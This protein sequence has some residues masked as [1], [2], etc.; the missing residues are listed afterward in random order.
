MDN[1]KL[2]L[3]AGVCSALSF[4]VTPKVFADVLIWYHF[5]E[6]E[7][8]SK[9]AYQAEVVN[10]APSGGFAGLIDCRNDATTFANVPGVLPVYQA[11]FPDGVRLY[12]PVTKTVRDNK[13]A[14]QFKTSINQNLPCSTVRIVDGDQLTPSDYTIEMFIKSYNT[15]KCQQRLITSAAWDL[16]ANGNGNG[17]GRFQDSGMSATVNGNALCDQSWHHVAIV[18]SGGTIIFYEDYKEIMRQTNMGTVN[19][20]TVAD[21][22]LGAPIGRSYGGWEGLIDEVRVCDVALSAS[23]FLHL[24]RAKT[25]VDPN[26]YFHFS[27]EEYDLDAFGELASLATNLFSYADLRSGGAL[28]NDAIAYQPGNRLFWDGTYGAKPTLMASELAGD[29]VRFGVTNGVRRMESFGLQFNA[30]QKKHADYESLSAY[31]HVDDTEDKTLAADSYTSECFIKY[32]SAPENKAQYIMWQYGGVNGS[33]CNSW[34]LYQN[35]GANGKFIGQFWYLDENNAIQSAVL[36]EDT[37]KRVSLVDGEW[38]HVA[39][40]YDKSNRTVSVYLDYRLYGYKVGVNML[41]EAAPDASMRK[42]EFGT[43][44]NGFE[45]QMNGCFDEIRITR[46]ALDPQEFLTTLPVATGKTLFW[47]GFDTDYTTAPYSSVS[48]TGVVAQASAART[49]RQCRVMYFDDNA[50]SVEKDKGASLEL[51]G[52]KVDYG[53]NL[54]LETERSVTVEFL[55]RVDSKTIG[56]KLVDF[57]ANGTTVWSVSADAIPVGMWHAVA[58]KID[59]SAGTQTLFV[60]GV[61][62]SS[63]PIAVPASLADSS[64]VLGDTGVIGKL[65]EVRVS[66]GVL[67]AQELFQVP[68]NGFVIMFR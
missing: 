35:C 46:R 18:R 47:A 63:G 56:A 22:I 43:G 38:H 42:I 48:P 39:F 59:A 54:M 19:Y 33:Q 4:F 52:G 6:C 44:Y 65:D 7:P 66:R 64:F 20:T 21:V 2:I 30:N 14:L 68:C 36:P 40:V 34:A 27:G 49:G 57:K 8:G 62:V 58:L 23:Q 37:A 11:A 61:Q 24:T 53:R 3:T 45:H 41:A 26:V 17:N 32:L 9:A 51:N 28:P 15:S 13:R 60:D 25:D 5:D 55:T 10:S 1:T 67:A 29:I 31:L 12:D 16:Y 50:Q